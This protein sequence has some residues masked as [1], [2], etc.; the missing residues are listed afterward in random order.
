MPPSQSVE[1]LPLNTP[2][3][4]IQTGDSQTESKMTSDASMT[5]LVIHRRSGGTNSGLC[6]VLTDLTFFPVP[7][8]S[9]QSHTNTTFHKYHQC[10]PPTSHPKLTRS[11]SL[12]KALL[13]KLCVFLFID[14]HPFPPLYPRGLAVS[15][16]SLHRSLILS[17]V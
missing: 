14:A 6:I 5:H 8:T 3:N 1:V 17:R 9:S 13:S 4:M 12:S 10:L 7:P 15:S 16:C 2:T 11:T